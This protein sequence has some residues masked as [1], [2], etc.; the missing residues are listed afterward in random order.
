[1]EEAA[2]RAGH[3]VLIGTDD[4]SA[5]V[6]GDPQGILGQQLSLCPFYLLNINII[7]YLLIGILLNY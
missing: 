3:E 7:S 2:V 4:N 5:L 6:T 1:L